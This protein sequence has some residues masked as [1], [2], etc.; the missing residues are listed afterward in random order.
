[1]AQEGVAINL[2]ESKKSVEQAL[3]ELKMLVEDEMQ[4]IKDTKYYVKPT[5]LR[6]EA[7]KKKKLNIRRYNRY[8]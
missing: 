5:S 8:K 7:M 1:M 6:R 3:R 4:K 2:K